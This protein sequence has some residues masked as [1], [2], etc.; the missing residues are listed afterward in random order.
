MLRRHLVGVV[1]A[2]TCMSCAADV[3]TDNDAPAS[4]EV[5]VA[6]EALTQS[7]R[8]SC[9]SPWAENLGGNLW[10]AGAYCCWIRGNGY[11]PRAN[12]FTGY[13]STDITNCNGTI[14]C[15]C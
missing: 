12:T 3:A 11:C 10:R 4:P 1:L 13:C 14:R 15:G 7:F 6:A 5:D 2:I 9:Q 8:S